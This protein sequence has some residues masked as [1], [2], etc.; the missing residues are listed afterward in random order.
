MKIEDIL[1][2]ADELEQRANELKTLNE[3]KRSA[4]KES[5]KRDKSFYG[6]NF[7]DMADNK[8]TRSIAQRFIEERASEGLKINSTG[9]DY[10]GELVEK[11]RIS[12]PLTGKASFLRGA[13]TGF[14][15]PL[16]TA[17]PAV[18]ASA[19]EGDT[20]LTIDN[21]MSISKK[22][23]NPQLYYSILGITYQTEKFSMISDDSI[24]DAF[25][26]SFGE[27]IEY[28]L[29]S[30]NAGATYPI[31]GIMSADAS[32]CAAGNAITA[33]AAGTVS[34][35]DMYSLADNA[36]GKI[37]NWTIVVPASVMSKLLSSSTADY[38]FCKEEY[39]RNG[40]IRGLD[41]VEIATDADYA[42]GKVIATLIDL[43]KNLKVCVAA[44]DVI[45]REVYD[46]NSLNKYLQGA[47]G[48][49]ASV[50]LPNEVWQLVGK[51]AGS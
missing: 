6:R 36:K 48:L 47:M 10:Y 17:R 31:C 35:E 38:N 49:A 13:Y 8:E 50:V 19:T 33:S 28:A 27:T 42:E 3:E 39:L 1:N 7:K 51:K 21:Q 9:M 44:D 15:I 12:K 23:I 11:F 14:Q 34:W 37:G 29:Q 32:V 4:K 25:A 43:T 24:M 2:K 46:K 20:N 40:K 30:R 41:V 16:I 22:T 45:L 5:E 26:E 18:N